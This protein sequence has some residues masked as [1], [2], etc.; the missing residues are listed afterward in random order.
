MDVREWLRGLGLERY[1]AAFREDE[2]EPVGRTEDPPPS[3]GPADHEAFYRALDQDLDTPE[4]LRVLDGA[5][6]A[7]NAAL[8][9]EGRALLGLD[10]P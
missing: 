10:R 5:E 2:I 8:V 4:A 1:E 9:E 6:A 7:G 3:G